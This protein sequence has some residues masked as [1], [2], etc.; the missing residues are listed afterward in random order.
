MELTITRIF[1]ARRDRVWK[2]WTDP[3]IFMKWWGPKYFSCPLAN[4]DLRIGGKY[5]VA[6]RGP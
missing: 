5:L 4:L 6:M 1:D 3:E 2:A